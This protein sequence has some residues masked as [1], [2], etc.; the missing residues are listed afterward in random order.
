MCDSGW[1][2]GQ[3][4]ESEEL[5]RRRRRDFPEECSRELS[6]DWLDRD[7]RRLLPLNG[8]MRMRKNSS[9]RNQKLR[10]MAKKKRPTRMSR[11][12]S[13]AICVWSLSP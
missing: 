2:G 12:G 10:S 6:D 8:L 9:I 1:C 7:L 5:E 13:P 11:P 4:L 3:G